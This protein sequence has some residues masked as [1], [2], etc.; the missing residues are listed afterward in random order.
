MKKSYLNK[1]GEF[2]EYDAHYAHYTIVLH[3]VTKQRS[4]KIKKILDER[5]K[6]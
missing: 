5:N 4:L 6:R 2:I 3:S 1:D